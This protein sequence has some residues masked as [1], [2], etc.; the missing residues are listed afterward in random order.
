MPPSI[1]ALDHLVLTVSDPDKTV[2][3]YT[4]VLGMRAETFHPAD[5]TRRI[6]LKF[7]AQK[8][9]LHVAGAE[10]EPRAQIPK[11]PGQVEYHRS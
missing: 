11:A 6:A 7:G 9:N 5:G 3:F 8:I 10:F 2:D 4:K 1:E